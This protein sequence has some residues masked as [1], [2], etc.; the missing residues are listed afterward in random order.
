MIILKTE[1]MLYF[2]MNFPVLGNA[3]TNAKETR[4]KY[5]QYVFQRLNPD[6]PI[7][8]VMP[9]NSAYNNEGQSSGAQNSSP[10]GRRI[11]ANH[12]WETSSCWPN[13]LVRYLPSGTFYAQLKKEPNLRARV[14]LR[15]SNSMPVCM[16][17]VARPAE[18]K[19][20]PE[21]KTY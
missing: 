11:S 16:V 20:R 5:L 4:M 1:S 8:Q 3:V 15:T 6:W 9:N 19:E 12:K 18:S 2:R 10:E 7:I 14:S 13:G 17:L 21:S